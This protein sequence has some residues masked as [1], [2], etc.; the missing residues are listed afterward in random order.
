MPD[1][2]RGSKLEGFIHEADWYATFCHLAGIDPTDHAAAAAAPALPPI[3]S[4]NVWPLITGTNSTSPRFEWAL[5]PFRVDIKRDDMPHDAA[6]MLGGFKLLVGKVWQNGWCGQL[7]PN[8]T[9]PWNT[10]GPGQ[11]LLCH[12]RRAD[13]NKRGCLFDVINDPEERHDLSLEM[14]EKAEEIYAK[15]KEAQ[16]TW[17]NPKRGFQG[18]ARK[19]D[20][21]ACHVTKSTG[22][23]GPWLN[24][25][26][27]LV[28]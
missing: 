18:S 6:Y 7:H 1:H 8:K 27:T 21:K 20:P 10:W 22:F 11:F 23:L 28:I 24:T 13:K 12:Y 2:V 5:T 26:V 14:P 17:Y 16:K 3:D 9:Q 4:L 25:S 19:P 15:M